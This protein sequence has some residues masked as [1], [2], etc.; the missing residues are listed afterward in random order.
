MKVKGFVFRL[1]TVGVAVIVA[2][3]ILEIGLRLSGSPRIERLSVE[4]SATRGWQNIAN[5]ETECTGLEY[6]EPMRFNSRGL[7]GPIYPYKKP[8]HTFRILLIG[9]SFTFGFAVK[10]E[11]RIGDRL[12]WQLN[13]ADLP[14]Q[15]EVISMGTMGY[16]TDQ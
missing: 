11:D 9:D 1:L 3:A 14:E 12:Q 10:T 7:R 6:N 16:G 2:L 4:Y 13:H 15:V 8:P 5:A